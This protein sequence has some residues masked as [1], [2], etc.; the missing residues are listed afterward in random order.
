MTSLKRSSLTP[1]T[2]TSSTSIFGVCGQ[3]IKYTLSPA[4][5]NA[6]FHHLLLNYVY[7]TFEILPSNI[8]QAVEGIRA[9][10]LA[11]INVTK[12]F[13]T[14]VL[15]YL[16]DISI[17]AEKIGSVNTIINNSG[18]L[19]GT[20]TDGIGLQ[21]SLEEK[22]VSLA[23]SRVLILGAGGAARAACAMAK[24]NKAKS[25]I[26]VARDT[27]RGQKTA[28][29]GGATTIGLSSGELRGALKNTD[30]IINTIPTNVPI[31]KSWFTEGHFVYDTRYDEKET[32]LMRDARSKG[33]QVSNGLS[34]L[35]YQGAESF[36]FWTG[37]KAPLNIMRKTLVD[38]LSQRK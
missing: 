1:N 24:N 8:S 28:T 2:I 20:S 36:E 37:R 14:E 29:V 11:G 4:M 12:P 33:A 23:N 22:K 27:A 31:D 19:I 32:Q 34:M 18:Q 5:H 13:K 3:D 25:V 38:P 26:V 30:L 35:L 21:R 16:D 15:P 9:L 7:L 6:A 17:E 10:G